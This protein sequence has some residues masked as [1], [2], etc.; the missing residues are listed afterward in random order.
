MKFFTH[1]RS[2]SVYVLLSAI[3]LAAGTGLAAAAPGVDFAPGSD[4]TDGG[5]VGAGSSDL[6][7]PEGTA[8]GSV[9]GDELSQVPA[10]DPQQ[11]QGR[12]YQVAAV[13]QPFTLQCTSNTTADYRVIDSDT[14]S[15][16]NTCSTLAG[17]QST[18][19]G[20]ARVQEP[21]NP[22]SL[23]VAFAGIPGQSLDGPVNYR[24]TYLEEDY[25]L[26]IVGDP[27]RFSGFV[28]SRTPS[29]TSAQ[30][31]TVKRVTAERGWWN[32][33]FLTTP[34]AEGRQDTSPLCLS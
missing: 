25:S 11:Y 2:A 19:S 30:W 3:S 31:N 9:G 14:I 5:R 22:G 20:Q 13:P 34:Q 26:A 24:V 18:I 23:R 1:S 16:D 29:L 8:V 12:W 6:R 32:C 4:I 15:V 10:L 17:G 7:L 21:E 27:Q 28:L 33:A